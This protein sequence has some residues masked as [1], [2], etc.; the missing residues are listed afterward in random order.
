MSWKSSSSTESTCFPSVVMSISPSKSQSSFP[1]TDSSTSCIML[2]L[3]TGLDATGVPTV[4]DFSAGIT[5]VVVVVVLTAPSPSPLE[6]FWVCFSDNCCLRASRLA[7]ISFCFWSRLS[8]NC[9]CFSA[10]SSSRFSRVCSSSTGCSTVDEKE[11]V[12][13]PKGDKTVYKRLVSSPNASYIVPRY[14]P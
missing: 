5:V 1:S 8:F 7:C 11:W 13:G 10:F 9:S 14:V 3:E 6:D 4:G 12:T 2:R